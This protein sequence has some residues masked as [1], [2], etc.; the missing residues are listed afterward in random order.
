VRTKRK[1]SEQ[2]PHLDPQLAARAR[3][4]I[5]RAEFNSEITASLETWCIRAL[6]ESGVPAANIARHSVPGCFEI[7]VV[8]QELARTNHFDVLIALGAVIRGETHHFDLIANECAR[9]VMHVSLEFG[10]PVIFE[11]LATYNR[12][13]A[14]RRAAN[15]NTNKGVEAAHAALF[16]MAAMKIV[17]AS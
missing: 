10:I 13:D 9:G 16:A 12:R 3:V 11:V 17:R 4:A 14:L 15:N 1:K 8:A 7:P 2:T 5:I 6:R